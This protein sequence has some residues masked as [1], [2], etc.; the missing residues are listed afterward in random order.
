[1]VPYR[2][3]RSKILPICI[4]LRCALRAEVA[5]NNGPISAAMI[6]NIRLVGDAAIA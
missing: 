3:E 1:M 6:I 4:P 5:G 2:V